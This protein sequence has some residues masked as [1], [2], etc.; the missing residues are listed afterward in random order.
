MPVDSRIVVGDLALDTERGEVEVAGRVVS[1]TPTESR[2]LASLAAT[3]GKV[4][5]ARELARDLG[6]SDV[7]DRDAQEIVKVNILR[8]RRKVEEDPAKPRRVVTQRG[9]GY[10]LASQG[11]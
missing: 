6:L 3:P 10:L 4:R 7:S 1:V 9:Y 5:P 8:L 11:D 2:L